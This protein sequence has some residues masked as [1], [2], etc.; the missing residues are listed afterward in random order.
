MIFGDRIGLKGDIMIKR[1]LLATDGSEG[2]HSAE[3][4]AQYLAY[5][6]EGELVALFVKDIRLIQVTEF[7][8]MGALSMPVSA[9]RDEFDQALSMRGDAVISTLAQSAESARV[10]FEGRMRTGR[11]YVI[12]AE[13]G[14]TADLVVLGRGGVGSS[15]E[16]AGI[17]GESERVVR[18]TA[19]PVLVAAPGYSKLGRMVV[20]YDGS[21]PATRALHQAA[22]LAEALDL[23]VL[24][25]T[26]NDDEKKGQARLDEALTYLEPRDL[27]KSV[28]LAAGDPA[29]R[30]LELNETSDLTVLGISG[31]RS[32]PRW[33]IGSTSE[34]V[35]RQA[36]GPTL[37]VP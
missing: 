33:L 6:L 23:P 16:P 24:V 25:V 10:P 22:D 37:L 4:L 36:I 26:V 27:Q 7:L 18:G 8:D 12:I 5:E 13:E 3:S 20:G 30:L 34:Y 21:G 31:H 19:V 28:S 1:I 32:V 17:G 35:L 2:A 9:Y 14:R 11:P 29:E 15:E